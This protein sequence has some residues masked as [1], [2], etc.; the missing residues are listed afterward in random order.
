MRLNLSA[1]TRMGR[2]VS[3]TGIGIALGLLSTLAFVA[4]TSGAQNGVVFVR[5]PVGAG[6]TAV[7]GYNPSTITVVIGVNDTVEW[8]NND[9]TTHHT[10]TPGNQPVGGPWVIGSGDMAPRD[11]YKFQFTVPGTYS[12]KC[13]Y[14]SLMMGTVVVKGTATPT[15][16]FPAAYLAIIFFAVVAAIMVAAPR[17]RPGPMASQPSG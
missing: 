14:H 2:I 17:L 1:R 16:E 15:P 7:P 13:D 11:S 4:P 9:T 3:A 5:M 6:T 12:Y 8:T 10:V